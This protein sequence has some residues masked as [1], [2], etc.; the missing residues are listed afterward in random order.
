MVLRRLKSDSGAGVGGSP[1]PVPVPGSPREDSESQATHVWLLT[2]ESPEAELRPPAGEERA[3]GPCLKE[4]TAQR[5]R[6]SGGPVHGV[7]KSAHAYAASGR[8]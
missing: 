3:A 8:K 5:P 1:S 6:G 2:A 4:R 7:L